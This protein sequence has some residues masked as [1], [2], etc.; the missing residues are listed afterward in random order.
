MAPYLMP[1]RRVFF[2]R[3]QEINKLA[4]EILRSSVT[5]LYGS[6][7]VGKSSLLNAG[8]I[9]V[10]NR[11]GCVVVVQNQWSEHDDIL[12]QTKMQLSELVNEPL[13]ETGLVDV[14]RRLEKDVVVLLDQFEDVFTHRASLSAL[15]EISELLGLED[16]GIRV[17][18]SI[19]DDFLSCL[20]IFQGCA[21]SALVHRIRLETLSLKAARDAIVCP[22][23]VYGAS[24]EPALADAVID[25]VRRASPSEYD[26]LEA[27]SVTDGTI[28]P[29][30]LQLVMQKIWEEE[31]RAGSSSLR[32][33]TLQ[34]VGGVK[35]VIAEY[36]CCAMRGRDSREREIAASLFGYMV[37]P[38]GL[39]VGR[40]LTNLAT[41]S[42]CS[43]DDLKLTLDKLVDQRVLRRSLSRDLLE[44]YEILHDVLA[45]P[46]LEWCHKYRMEQ[47]GIQATRLQEIRITSRR[48][49]WTIV[50][51]I[52]LFL[53]ASIILYVW[54]H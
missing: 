21:T 41:Y 45:S 53:L 25:Q 40:P 51:L 52:T 47:L 12:R 4:D 32:L 9:P 20:D 17:V 33:S 13:N 43:P 28:E 54:H 23:V 15:N 6:S 50:V 11:D 8:V 16:S 48:I 35:R 2:G 36:I 46:L 24:I 5:V 26:G 38:T 42:G 10:L 29:A 34:H 31:A 14:G 37:T 7:G 18:I 3:D 30:Y 1:D 44:R 27:F 49:A 22:V 39:E 19:R